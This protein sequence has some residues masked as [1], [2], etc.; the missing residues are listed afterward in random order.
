[1][2]GA[3]QLT[4]AVVLPEET[5]PIVGALVTVAGV[6]LLEAAEAALLPAVRLVAFTV[7]VYAV[8]AVRPEVTVHVVAVATL[9]VQVPPAGL[10]VAV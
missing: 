7:N 3:V 5:A 4:V 2:D 1:L 8:P 10:D 9:V 6:T